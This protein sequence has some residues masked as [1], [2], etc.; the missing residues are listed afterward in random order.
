M[1]LSDKFNK[2]S[3]DWKKL[4][5][6]RNFRNILLFLVFVVIAA[7]FWLIMALNDSVQDSMDVRLKIH[8]IPQG[9]TFIQEPPKKIHVT[10]R[11]KGT[12]MLRNSVLHRPTLNINFDEYASNGVFRF[13][14]SDLYS[15]LR[16]TFGSSAQI[17]AVSIDSLRLNYTNGPGRRVPLIVVSDVTPAT[18]YVIAGKLKCSRSSVVLYSDSEE[19]DTITRVYTERIV[20][21]NLSATEKVNVK[22]LSP[23]KGVRLEPAVVT[24]TIPIETLVKKKSTVPVKVIN[25]PGNES[26]MIFPANVEVTYFVPMSR[27]NSDNGEIVVLADYNDM[28]KH[29]GNRMPIRVGHHGA[30]VRNV[31]L[32]T[33]SVEYTIVRQ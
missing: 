11:D 3:N 5:N 21:R 14:A 28:V 7:L 25:V 22:V 23:G 31:T 18:G 2:W 8:N 27:F 15:A 9:I 1:K 4:R 13:S 29:R 32:L 33:D 24:V 10:V 26:L 17:T 19:A 30:E 16:S 20:K 12:S 6:T